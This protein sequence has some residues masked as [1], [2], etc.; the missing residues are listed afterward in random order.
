[1][2]EV[3][4][5]ALE[6]E[7]LLKAGSNGAAVQ[8]K[9]R[10]RAGA[11]PLKSAQTGEVV[12]GL[13]IRPRFGWS[14]VGQ[15]LTQIGW[16]AAPEFLSLPMVPGSGREIPP[17]VLAGPVLARLAALLSTIRRGYSLKEEVLLQPRGRI[18]WK[19]YIQSSLCRG[20]WHHLPCQY[21]DL[22]I[23][24][25][26]RGNV[27]WALERI[28][29]ELINVGKNDP[30][31]AL[32]AAQALKLIDSL[33]DVLALLPNSGRLNR[34]LKSALLSSEV[35]SRGIEALGWIVDERGL[36]GGQEQNGLAWQLPLEQLWES[37]VES[38]VRKEVA[39]RGGEVKVGRL[40]ETVFPLYW[41]DP[42]HR[43]LGHLVP[44]VVVRRGPEVWII[45]A[46][47]KAHLAEIDETGWR[48]FTED[49]KESHRADIH[50]ALAYAALYEAK[51]VTATLMYPLR[52]G[53]WESLSSRG[54][55]RSIAELFTAGR[56][57]RLE[58]RG[59][60]FGFPG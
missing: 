8:L 24:P 50:Q 25:E 21:P 41:T 60:P 46:K 32:L 30:V 3:A 17:W 27:R 57:L 33:K 1:M 9:P 39:I 43:S 36:G 23:D 37:Y 10:G 7:P 22:G 6:V 53:T 34:L 28:R 18:V 12:S 15:I 42:T 19:E 11:I 31:A 59:V 14:G 35:F 52:I 40:R 47:Y 13:V 56:Q 20:R 51:T 58:L 54:R 55:D 5:N 2:N 29:R 49:L 26:L 16:Q 44:D 48:Q 45:D 4:L 38:L